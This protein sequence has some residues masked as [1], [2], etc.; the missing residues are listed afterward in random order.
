M[1]HLE[2][3]ITVSFER[4]EIAG[5]VTHHFRGPRDADGLVEL[6]TRDLAI[7]R[8]RSGTASRLRE[9]E[10]ELGPSDPV[11]GQKLRIQAPAGADRLE[12][13]YHSS[14]EASGLQWLSPAQT[15]GGRLPY[16]YSQGQ[17][18]HTRSWVPCVDAPKLRITYDAVVRVPENLVAVM[19]AEHRDD[20]GNPGVYRFHMPHP[21]PTY[22]IAIAVGDLAFRSL[23]PRSGVW[24][25]PDV[26]ERAAT[27][28]ADTEAMIA[29]TESLFGPYRWGR[30]DV[31]V[32]PPSFPLGGME[33]PRLTFATPT[34]LA[35]D[36]SLV[37][38][39]AHELAHSWSGNLVTNATW[40]DFWLNEG[41]TVYI[42]RRIQEALYG[43]ERS[44]MEAAIGRSHLQDTLDE[45]GHDSRDTW[46]FLDLEGRDPDG[47][48]NSVPYEKGYLFLRLVEETFGR[49]RFDA[50]LRGYF[51]ENAF[52]PMTTQRFV[53]ILRRNLLDQ[54]PDRAAS[55]R[56]EEW[57]YG[58][59]VPDN[60]PVAA[61]D[62]FTKVAARA[63]AWLQKSE[64]IPPSVAMQWT[65]HE[66]I[67]FL[68]ALPRDLASDRM[69]ELDRAFHLTRTGNSEILCEW[70][71]L[72][73][74]TGYREAFDRLREF[75]THV[76]RKKFLQP[77]YQ[78]MVRREAT[79]TLAREIYAGARPGYHSMSRGTLDK[80][81]DFEPA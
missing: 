46:L 30:Y 20:E 7:E 58:P 47:A 27:E 44:E 39:I 12:I 43:R 15:A 37:S 31:L 24:S 62:A 40:N 34:L 38:V 53:E 81:L 17:S 41:F 50:F 67:H 78:E 28:F 1:K 75:L 59:G 18:I 65:A 70:L 76:G 2:L 63:S 48:I 32:L 79:R 72:A 77:I 64:P 35:G 42:E 80:V 13:A 60:A 55:I 52:E 21:I 22:L 57:I 25:E 4:K 23:G 19:A 6:D 45:L 29:A 56:L 10:F 11:Q 73:V 69:A 16:L 14:P 5:T 8:V 71:L 49:D 9:V 26:V 61:S 54:D 68:R 3:D 74:A 33:N 51:D 66:W 36:K